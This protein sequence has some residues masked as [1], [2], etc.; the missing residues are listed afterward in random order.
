MAED[1]GRRQHD[2]NDVRGGGGPS[3]PPH[4][5]PTSNIA[6]GPLRQGDRPPAAPAPGTSTPARVEIREE[7]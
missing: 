1:F 7:E 6:F 4:T 5:W 2:P 3:G